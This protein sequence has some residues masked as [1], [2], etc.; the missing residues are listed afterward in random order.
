MVTYTKS[1]TLKII[2][3]IGFTIFMLIMI[4]LIIIVAQSRF[5]GMEP[6]LFGNRLY[7][8]DSGSMMPALDINSL[9]I[10]REKPASD[11]EIGDIITYSAN[12]N[13]MR[14][15]HRVVDIQDNG[16]AFITRG[17]ANNVDDPN[18]IS[19]DRVIGEVVYSIPYI[20]YGLR[21][22]SSTAG[23]VFIIVMGALSIIIPMIYR[24]MRA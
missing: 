4:L 19:K 17:D 12:N 5:T 6:S 24:K 1:R 11:I 15:T 23:I 2:S 3:N 14:V 21:F 22:L 13:T 8:V 9:L 10:V 20:G 7:I 18:P 16:E